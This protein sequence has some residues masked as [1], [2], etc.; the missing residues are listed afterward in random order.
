MKRVCFLH[1]G[2]HKTGTTSVQTLLRSNEQCLERNGIF[3]PRSG[4]WPG[5]GG[6]HNLAWELNRESRFNPA[7]GTWR[8]VIGEIR[9]HDPR[10]VCISSEDFAKLHREPDTLCRMRQELNSIGY[11]VKIVVYLRPQADYIEALYVELV[12][13]GVEL[14]KYGAE[15]LKYGKQV[16]G[17][18]EYSAEILRSGAFALR[19]GGTA[20]FDYRELLDTF[21]NAFG[22]DSMV[23]RPY[24]GNRESEYLLNDFISVISAGHP[25]SGLDFS[26]CRERRNQT[27]SFAKAVESLIANRRKFGKGNFAPSTSSVPDGDF[28]H[29]PF[30]PLDLRDLMRIHR[31]F[32][33]ANRVV[34]Q[35]Y[36]VRI[37][38][39][40]RHR[41]LQELKCSLGLNPDSARRKE[42]LLQLDG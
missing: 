33:K 7:L 11:Q 41:L 34:R 6:H 16:R 21:A 12:K 5:S 32:G 24:Q 29:G 19:V 15:P 8:D 20:D 38:T 31:R 4:L 39:M 22:K 30:D 26:P 1:I 42:V 3:I 27:L 25:I 10:V 18:R 35:Q 9:S 28:M 14:V 23:V 36:Q 37:P 2:T 13:D 40:T 17:F